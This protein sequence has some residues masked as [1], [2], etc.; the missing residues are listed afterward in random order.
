MYHPCLEQTGT[1]M[2]GVGHWESGPRHCAGSFLQQGNPSAISSLRGKGPSNGVGSRS[3]TEGPTPVRLLS[4]QVFHHQ[5]TP[6][7]SMSG[8][9]ARTIQRACVTM[10]TAPIAPEY[11]FVQDCTVVRD[12]VH[13]NDH[14]KKH[15]EIRE[16]VA[17]PQDASDADRL[18]CP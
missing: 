9:S 14:P 16:V 4:C 11:L 7:K 17:T 6:C 10:T 13:V 2:N 3:R 15:C 8:P 1:S 5:D 12:W 18:A